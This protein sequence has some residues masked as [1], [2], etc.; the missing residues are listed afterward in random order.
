MLPTPF[1]ALPLRPSSGRPGRR[2]PGRLLGLIALLLAAC[3]APQEPA[4]PLDLLAQ[5]ARWEALDPDSPA[6]R[7]RL[8]AQGLP[9][10]G[11]PLPQWDLPA[12]TVLAL[13]RQPALAEAR[14]RL[15]AAEAVQAVQRPRPALALDLASHSE[16]GAASDSPWSLG[17]ALESLPLGR[18]GVARRAA[19]AEARRAQVD[20]AGLEL[21]R[22]AWTIRRTLRERHRDWW[23]ARS[24]AALQAER[25]ALAEAREQALRRQQAQG[26][27][28]G[29]ALRL[30]QREAAAARAV[31]AAARGV[32]A[33]ARLAL[34]A[35]AGL[36]PEAT[37]RL[38]LDGT[39]PEP[40]TLEAGALQ[41]AA[42]LNRLDLRAALARHAAA[43]A[44]QR[45]E[46]AR[47]WP[48]FSFAPGLAW[49]QGD[50][51]WSLGLRVSG[52]PAAGN[53]PA[54]ARAR[55]EREEAAATCLR[56]QAEA[57]VEL[58]QARLAAEA[59]EAA[60]AAAEAALAQAERG[61]ARTRAGLAAGQADRLALLDA[62][63]LVL[64]ARSRLLAARRQQAQ[65]RAALE[66]VLQLPLERLPAPAAPL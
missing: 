46:L 41:T 59:G 63:A 18:S 44:R 27:A 66:D 39:P 5:Q 33:Q 10:A 49:D 15:A 28:D 19:E 6:L 8:Q 11:W 45:A 36:T 58:A 42:L 16:T 22:T 47:R 14:A 65:A 7:E 60:G 17:I 55:A 48:E 52:P 61:L 4:E 26:A 57:L 2:R 13:T 50:R 38:P 24:E 54:L 62:Q 32:E 37:A 12:L 29:P 31:E 20:E 56:L 40:P 30:A 34:G 3:A 25:L 64:D 43:E 23:A 53:L 51:L 1:P 9:V 35:A 21:A